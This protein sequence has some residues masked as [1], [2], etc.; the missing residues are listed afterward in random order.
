MRNSDTA[1]IKQ[2]LERIHGS[3]GDLAGLIIGQK[4]LLE[5]LTAQIETNR[6]DQQNQIDILKRRVDVLFEMV[7]EAMSISRNALDAAKEANEVARQFGGNI[8]LSRDLATHS[9]EMLA[10]AQQQLENM[11]MELAAL[12]QRNGEVT[13]V[14]PS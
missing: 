9:R 11:R 13:A 4:T 6:L 7:A 12:K 14:N 5:G 8:S 3:V 10:L 1:E 2:T